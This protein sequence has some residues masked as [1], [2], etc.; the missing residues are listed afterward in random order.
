MFICRNFLD[1]V[2]IFSSLAPNLSRSNDNAASVRSVSL[3]CLVICISPRA[4]FLCTGIREIKGY[5]VHF[6]GPEH[7]FLLQASTVPDGGARDVKVD[8]HHLGINVV[9][10]S[11]VLCV[12]MQ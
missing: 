12:G 9:H 4:F 5:L 2:M 3:L 6:R 7:I 8:L 10:V 11:G 1:F